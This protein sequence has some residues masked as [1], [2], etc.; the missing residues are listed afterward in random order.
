V[1]FSPGQTDGGGQATTQRAHGV[2][3]RREWARVVSYSPHRQQQKLTPLSLSAANFT[4][5]QK[6]KDWA[7]S[8]QGTTEL[9]SW[10][11]A[12]IGLISGALGPCTLFLLVSP[13]WPLSLADVS[14]F[15]R[16]LQR[17]VRAC[18]LDPCC[19]AQLLA[20]TL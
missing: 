16:S 13:F 20:L 10:Q 7:Q 18:P 6:I 12:G 8:Y 15:L 1:G 5:Y 19:A 17:P 2:E 11:T 9:P 4:A 14:P 3:R